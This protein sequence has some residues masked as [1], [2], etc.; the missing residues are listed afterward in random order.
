M[1][2]KILMSKM[3]KFP[4]REN[5]S[6]IYV[7]CEYL[8]LTHGKNN[9]IVIVEVFLQGLIEHKIFITESKHFLSVVSFFRLSWMSSISE[10]FW[11]PTKSCRKGGLLITAAHSH[12][13]SFR[14][15][16]VVTAAGKPFFQ[17]FWAGGSWY[18]VT[19]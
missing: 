10:S 11:E 19:R 2:C 14:S 4:P 17:F 18:M 5:T 6:N 12:G 7:G 3:S 13:A 1:C 8:F 15:G 16:A 9:N